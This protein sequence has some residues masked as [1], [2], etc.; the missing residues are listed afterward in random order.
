M[1]TESRSMELIGQYGFLDTKMKLSPLGCVLL[2]S[3]AIHRLLLV[4]PNFSNDCPKDKKDYPSQGYA[5]TIPHLVTLEGR[6]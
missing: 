2:G 4:V 5:D 6:D 3:G 1:T